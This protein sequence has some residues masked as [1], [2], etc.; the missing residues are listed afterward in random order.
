MKTLAKIT[1]LAALAALVLSGCQAKKIAGLNTTVYPISVTPE[2]LRDIAANNPGDEAIVIKTDAPYWIV[3]CSDWIKPDVTHG[4]GGGK[5]QIITLH[6]ESNYKGE[7]KT[8][9]PRSGEVKISGGMNS[10]VVSVN[11]L[12]HEAVIDPSA[13][14]GG[15]PDLD[16]FKD[17]VNAVNDGGALNRWTNEAGEIAL[18][19]DLDLSGLDEWTPIGDVEKTDNGNN[20]SKPTGEFFTGV[21]NGGGHTISGFKATAT[22][23]ANKTWGLFGYVQ[24]GTIKDL[25]L[26]GV[27]ITIGATGAAD[28]GVVVGTLKNSTIENVTV[29]GKLD[30]KGSTST[31]R[32]AMGGIAGFIVSEKKEDQTEATV[33]TLVKGCSVTLTVKGDRG[34]NTGNGATGCHFGGIAGFSTNVSKDISLVKIESCTAGGDITSNFGRS[35][36]IVAA[37]NYGTLIEGSTNNMDQ[38]NTFSGGSGGRIAN[39]T[40]ILGQNGGIT[41]C[42]NNGS[43]TTTESNCQSGGL[44]CLLNHASVYIKGGAN[45]GDIISAFVTDASGRDFRGLLC[46]NFSAFG[47][48]TGVTVSGRVGKY[49]ANGTPQWL[50]VNADNFIE[51]KYIG[52]WKD[53]AAKAK[54]T[55]LTYVAPSAP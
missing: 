25:N 36:G 50:D 32:F 6:F 49:V 27:D 8:T 28:A 44:V 42:V 19:A 35:S 3:T 46:A 9:E 41:D 47:E 20:A 55:G 5:G 34:S 54:I 16:E 53:D 10:F 43:I 30:L 22:L 48:V 23:A 45:Y 29:S 38:V 7:A 13:S 11:Q 39:I 18:L 26:T 15:I 40:C 17:F 31:T 2:A 1:T 14:I 37:A 51:G 52:Y 21:F 12:G 4:V 24:D 33:N